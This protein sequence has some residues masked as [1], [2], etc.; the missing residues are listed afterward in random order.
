MIELFLKKQNKLKTAEKTQAS[1]MKVLIKMFGTFY[2]DLFP[3]NIRTAN[4]PNTEAKAIFNLFIW[5][6]LTNR[7][8][9]GKL[10]WRMGQVRE[11]TK[12]N[13]NNN[14]TLFILL[15]ATN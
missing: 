9:I 1:I 4:T 8:E 14:L 12:L 5:S 13:Y 7:V 2:V 6:L 11:E 15:V 3:N 10:F